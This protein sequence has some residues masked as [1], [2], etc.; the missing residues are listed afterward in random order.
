M[1]LH[2]LYS[3]IMDIVFGEIGTIPYMIESLIFLLWATCIV[4][5][6]EISTAK[7]INKNNILL[8][9]YKGEKAS[10]IM[11]F[12]ELFGLP[13]K[14][15]CVI[16]G[17]DALMLKTRKETFQLSSSKAILKNRDNYI[18]IDTGKAVTKK[19]TTEMKKYSTVPASKGGLRIRCIEAIQDL[20]AMIGE[21]WKPTNIFHNVPSIYLR[22][23]V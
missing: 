15:M 9:F 18:I 2:G 19:F 3:H 14:S 21:K 8:A 10:F 17:D 4:Y 5:S 23:C 6:P 20:L 7:T 13:V 11:N 1:V 22:K 12:F 16:A